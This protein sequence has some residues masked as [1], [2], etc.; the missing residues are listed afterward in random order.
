M[1]PQDS[2]LV[3]LVILVDRLPM[4]ALPVKR[5]RGHPKVYPDRLFLK[6]VVIQLRANQADSNIS[7][8]H[9]VL[10]GNCLRYRAIA[11]WLIKWIAHGPA[12]G[13]PILCAAETHR[14]AC[15]IIGYLVL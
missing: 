10:C 2:L 7:C 8:R 11:K 12:V 3:M 4:P 1:V 6:A 5:G 14:A 15:C 9:I 13:V